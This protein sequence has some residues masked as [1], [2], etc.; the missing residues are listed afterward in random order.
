MRLSRQPMRPSTTTSGSCIN[1][2]TICPS[3]STAPTVQHLGATQQIHPMHHPQCVPTPTR[4]PTDI[5]LQAPPQSRPLFS[6]QRRGALPSWLTGNP[7]LVGPRREAV[8]DADCLDTGMRK[9]SP[10]TPGARV[11]NQADEATRIHTT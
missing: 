4:T 10:W 1:R 8:D 2:T 3:L 7:T 11:R 5:C 9:R 6:K